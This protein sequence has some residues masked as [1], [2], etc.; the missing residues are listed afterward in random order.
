MELSVEKIRPM[1]KETEDIIRKFHDYEE[2]QSIDR[3]YMFQMLITLRFDVIN[4][5]IHNVRKNRSIMKREDG[6]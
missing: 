4:N 3:K 6:Q 5:M 2:S 1:V